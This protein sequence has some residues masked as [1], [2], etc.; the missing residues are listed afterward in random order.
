MKN[1]QNALKA[2]ISASLVSE[3]EIY[4]GLPSHSILLLML[5]RLS[6]YLA[7]TKLIATDSCI[8]LQCCQCISKQQSTQLHLLHRSEHRPRVGISQCL[9]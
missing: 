2:R 8:H 5:L 7:P 9:V 3:R 1:W 4:R 6:P